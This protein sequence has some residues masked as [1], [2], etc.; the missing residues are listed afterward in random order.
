MHRGSL[1][2]N[3]ILFFSRS[4]I[5][6]MA[7]RIA[8]S[9][10]VFSLEDYATG[11]YRVRTWLG[12]CTHFFRMIVQILASRIGGRSENVRNTIDAGAWNHGGWK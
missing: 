7:P 12:Y 3:T 5:L 8:R 10:P 4:V 6:P 11:P 2:L 9:P 1:S